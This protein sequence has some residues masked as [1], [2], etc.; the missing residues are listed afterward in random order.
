MNKFFKSESSDSTKVNHIFFVLD[1]SGSMEVVRQSMLDNL[2]E[3][4]QQ[5]QEDAPNDQANFVTILS[6][7]KT[8]NVLRSRVPLSKV[9]PL[10]F[11]EYRTFGN[12]ALHDAIART[13]G[14]ASEAMNEF[15]NFDNATL[16]FILTDGKDNAS[17]EFIMRS[18][19]KKLIDAKKAEGNF[20]FTFMGCSESLLRDAISIGINPA[21]TILYSKNKLGLESLRMNNVNS[22]VNYFAARSLGET[23]VDNFYADND[24]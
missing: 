14:L 20:T 8:I 21:S 11:E 9:K 16:M 10:T 7:A 6:F 1:R 18:D 13:I 23:A 4:I 2:N 12:T 15:I 5:M 17:E 19:I 24:E 3:Q 22:T